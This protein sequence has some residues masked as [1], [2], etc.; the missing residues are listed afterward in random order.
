M[1]RTPLKR[2]T[3]IRKKRPGTRRGEPTPAEKK[4]IRDQIYAETRGHCMLRFQDGSGCAGN[5]P[6]L[7]SDGSVFERWHLVHLKAK[8]RFGWE[9]SNLTGG[10]AACHLG[11][12]HAG[13]SRLAL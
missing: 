4:A 9:R 2:K 13:K 3:P 8:R 1:K 10:C 5:G 12:L 6:Q 11:I 7:P